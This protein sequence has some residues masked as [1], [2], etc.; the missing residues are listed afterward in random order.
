[1]TGRCTGAAGGEDLRA[2]WAS[3]GRRLKGE[4][5]SQRER[6]EKER[7]ALG[8]G[9]DAGVEVYEQSNGLGELTGDPRQRRRR[10]KPPTPRGCCGA[11]PQGDDL[12]CSRM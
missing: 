1:M 11:T 6:G 5:G 12:T 2:L 7:R 3:S 8:R 9:V 4:K 10:A